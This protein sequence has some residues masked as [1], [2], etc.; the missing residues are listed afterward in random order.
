MLKRLRNGPIAQ[1]VCLCITTAVFLALIDI[2]S[3]EITSCPTNRTM[4]ANLSCAAILGDLTG[5][6]LSS[7]PATAITQD[8]VAGTQLGLGDILVTFASIKTNGTF[9]CTAV[10]TVV[11]TTPLVYVC[12]TNKT[13]ECGSLWNFDEPAASNGCAGTNVTLMMRHH[14][15][16]ERE[17]SSSLIWNAEELFCLGYLPSSAKSGKTKSSTEL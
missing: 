10:I 11:N 4:I 9:I 17:T 8:L 3:A 6:L 13:V 1:V 12:N 15:Q 5:Q 14:S 2:T 7:D 16:P